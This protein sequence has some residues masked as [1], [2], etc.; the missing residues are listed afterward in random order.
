MHS[1]PSMLI[2]FYPIYSFFIPVPSFWVVD[3]DLH[4]HPLVLVSWLSSY[5]SVFRASGPDS[6]SR[7]TYDADAPYTISCISRLCFWDTIHVYDHLCHLFFERRSYVHAYRVIDCWSLSSF[8]FRFFSLA[9]GLITCL[10]IVSNN[11]SFVFLFRILFPCMLLRT[12]LTFIRPFSIL[13]AS[14]YYNLL[15]VFR[16]ISSL[17]VRVSSFLWFVFVITVGVST[18]LYHP[19]RSSIS[20]SQN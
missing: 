18:S 13:N 5:R 6:R 16:V 4:G 3:V 10:G 9:M 14:Q 2:G 12:R 11:L 1:T 20:I 8:S 17:T 7:T 19:R 15:F